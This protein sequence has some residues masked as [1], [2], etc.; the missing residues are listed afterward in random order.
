MTRPRPEEIAEEIFR[1]CGAG[2]A[3]YS[4]ARMWEVTTQVPNAVHVATLRRVEGLSGI[5]QTE[6]RN[7]ARARLNSREIALIELLRD[8]NTY[9]ESGWTA[10]VDKYKCAVA[11]KRVRSEAV[12][13]VVEAEHNACTRA[14]FERLSADA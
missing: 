13:E 8:P 1:D 6:R 9:V 4:A 14:N 2:P 12:R 11:E 7:V 5:K 3:G 10:L